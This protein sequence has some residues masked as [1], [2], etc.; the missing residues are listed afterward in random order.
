MITK[1][2][3]FCAK[4]WD[5]IKSKA[6]WSIRFVTHLEKTNFEAT[7]CS[8]CE[9]QLAFFY[10][11]ETWLWRYKDYLPFTRGTR[12]I[13]I[14]TLASNTNESKPAWH[15]NCPRPF[16]NMLQMF[17]ELL[18]EPIS[19]YAPSN[20]KLGLFLLIWEKIIFNENKTFPPSFLSLNML[21]S[22]REKMLNWFR[23]GDI[24]IW[25]ETLLPIF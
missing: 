5:K 18:K 23:T 20:E 22:G 11:N 4:R 21:L 6:L 17:C 25:K 24:F 12:L 15:C 2:N 14:S 9:Q 19:S 13:I 10:V 16:D 8:L 7:R 1:I 3:F